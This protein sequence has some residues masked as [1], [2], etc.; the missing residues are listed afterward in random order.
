MYVYKGS[1]IKKM[2]CAEREASRYSLL[3]RQE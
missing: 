1:A 2:L 3:E